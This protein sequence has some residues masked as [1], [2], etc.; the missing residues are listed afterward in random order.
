MVENEIYN[1]KINLYPTEKSIVNQPLNLSVKTTETASN[2]KEVVKPSSGRYVHAKKI[3]R[4]K[5][6]GI[7]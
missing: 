6:A 1:S 5:S 4:T 3:R 2:I 7:F